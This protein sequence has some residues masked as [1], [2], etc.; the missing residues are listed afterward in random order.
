MNRRIAFYNKV[1]IVIFTALLLFSYG[2]E[3]KTVTLP[4]N[5]CQ[6]TKEFDHVLENPIS[7]DLTPHSAIWI[8]SDSDFI[9]YSFPGSGTEIDPYIIENYEIISSS[10]H[11]IYI[12]STTNYFVIRNSYVDAE[13]YGIYVS[14]VADETAAV[15]NNTCYNNDND[16]ISLHYSGSSIV[17][18]NTCN[19]NNVYG[20]KL[21]FSGS[22]TVSNNTCNNNNDFGIVLVDSGSSTVANNTCNYNGIGI[23]LY[24]SGSSTFTNN[25]C[26]NNGWGISLADSGSSTFTNNMC[27][28]NERGISLSSSGNSTFTNNTCSNNN[29]YGIFLSDS[30]SSTVSN[31]TCNNNNWDGISLYFSN[32]CNITYNFLQENEGYGVYLSY[33]AYL[34]YSSDNCT[35]HHNTLVDNNLGG[36]SQAYDRGEENFWYDPETKEGNYWSDLGSKCTYKIDGKAHSKDLYPLNRAQS[37]PTNPITMTILSIVLPLLVSVVILAFVVPKYVVPY[38]RKTIIP[39][40]RRRKAER[41]DRIAK[42]LSC[43]NCGEKVKLSV[44]LCE[45]CGTTLPERKLRVLDNKNN[46]IVIVYLSLLFLST[47]IVPWVI[48]PGYPGWGWLLFAIF[49]LW[50]IFLPVAVII[51]PILFQ[52]KIGK[53]RNKYKIPIVILIILAVIAMVVGNT[54]GILNLVYGFGV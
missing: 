5:H 11:G 43:P 29:H 31:N 10:D 40:F 47:A 32:F 37:C 39:Y 18:N 17:A 25:T 53:M 45:N 46:R 33:N 14:N 16:G 28:N 6:I 2:L 23:S 44:T 49:G 50:G 24:Y 51:L 48:V 9:T 3:T 27:T 7:F 13:E 1:I 12:N 34:V 4:S 38:T 41:Q 15:I 21:W 8:D 54:F 20:I 26:S 19:N 35:I 42:L 52:S 22:S 36:S 30:S